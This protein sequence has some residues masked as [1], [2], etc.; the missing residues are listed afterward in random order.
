M[1]RRAALPSTLAAAAVRGSQP[2]RV[3][4]QAGDEAGGVEQLVMITEQP[5]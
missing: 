4:R 1:A 5:G 2:T 3:T